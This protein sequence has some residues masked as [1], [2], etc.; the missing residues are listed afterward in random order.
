MLPLTGGPQAVP[1][2]GVTQ[3]CCPA[4][5]PKSPCIWC[6]RSPPTACR[7]SHLLGNFQDQQQSR[8]QACKPS[9]L[10][11][12]LPPSAFLCNQLEPKAKKV[13]E[14]TQPPPRSSPS[15][16]SSLTLGMTFLR[17]GHQMSFSR[18]AEGL[19]TP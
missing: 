4:R 6:S 16:P 5:A 2:G 18:L 10:S 1:G 14:E 17:P 11:F 8:T 12:V 19:A 3:S 9:P 13:L 7:P 15:H